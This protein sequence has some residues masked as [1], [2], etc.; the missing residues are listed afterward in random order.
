M[1][2]LQIKR[3]K[4]N[5]RHKLCN[6]LGVYDCYKYYRKNKST[7]F[8][9]LSE[10]KYYSLIRCINNK[11]GEELL[12]GNHIILPQ[13]LGTIELRKYNTYINYD[14]N[15]KKI[16]TN[17][18]I[19]WN[20]TIQ[21]WATDDVSY[22]Q[23]LLVRS[24][25]KEVFKI[26]YNKSKAKYNNKVYYEFSLNRNLKIKLKQNIKKGLIDAFLFNKYYE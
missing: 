22:K 11:L 14:E 24:N 17:M 13:C 15:T 3:V 6:S 5:R 1:N 12:K 10:S 9:T 23:K 16:K 21:L 26:H 25:V 18:P 4:D 2:T 20:Q 19:D 7:K 8:K